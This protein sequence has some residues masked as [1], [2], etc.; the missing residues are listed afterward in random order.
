MRQNGFFLG[1]YLPLWFGGDGLLFQKIPKSP[2]FNLL[3]VYSDEGG[4]VLKA[5]QADYER[6]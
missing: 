2:D 4:S 6:T 1:G 5:V 3:H